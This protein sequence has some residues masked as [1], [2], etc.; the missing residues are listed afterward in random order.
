MNMKE[1][2]LAAIVHHEKTEHFISEMDGTVVSLGGGRETFENGPLGG[3]YDGFGLK[4]EC[5]DSANGQPVPAPGCVVLENIEDWEDVV[6]FPDLDAY[7]W[8][9][10]AE[11]QLANVNRD[12]QL[13]DYSTW[14]AQFLRVTHLMGFMDGLCAF[15]EEPEICKAFVDA[16]SDYKIRI[17][18]RV[19]KYF[20]PDFFTLFDDVATQQSLFLSPETYR[21]IIKPGHKKVNDAAIA[22]GIYPKIHTCGCCEALI[23]DYIDEG[24]VAWTAA[25]PINDIV[26]ILKKYGSQ[27]SVIGGYDTNGLP[28]QEDAPYEVIEK[29]VK[30]CLDTYAPYGS[31]AFLGFRIMNSSDPNAFL[32]GARPINEAFQKLAR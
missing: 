4:W 13:L 11:K 15:A 20:K 24:N 14:N 28:G 8:K 6:H 30:R 17:L 9:G 5:S 2:Y 31:Y 18:E 25:Q 3:G 19:E 23:P 21:E 12:T 1:E 10:E 16:I 32:E 26:G 27:I 7:D 29:E 22:M